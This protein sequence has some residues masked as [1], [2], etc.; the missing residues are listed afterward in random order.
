MKA[1]RV[2]TSAVAALSMLTVGPAF[3]APASGTLNGTGTLTV[4][5]QVT[6]ACSVG[7]S[8]LNF[9]PYNST[10]GTNGSGTV[11]VTCPA[12]TNYQ[13]GLGLGSYASGTAR[14]MAD[15]SG[16]F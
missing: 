6:G 14:R 7:N 10:T 2:V 9:G 16:N 8:A 12:S 1:R 3:A 4:S 13:V 15:G 11:T 5:A